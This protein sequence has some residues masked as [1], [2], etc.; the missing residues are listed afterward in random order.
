M[1]GSHQ[2]IVYGEIHRA[3]RPAPYSAAA[4]IAAPW[5][6]QDKKKRCFSRSR[7]NVAAAGQLKR[8]M[9]C[10]RDYCPPQLLPVLIAGPIS[11]KPSQSILFIFFLYYSSG[12]VS[13]PAG[14]SDWEATYIS[15]IS[16]TDPARRSVIR[17]FPFGE[18]GRSSAKKINSACLVNSFVAG[19]AGLLDQKKKE[20]T[21]CVGL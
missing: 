13:R 20:A 19:Q 6:E 10:V 21:Q 7:A 2:S 8:Y 4:A 18:T 5:L 1:T 12:A 3:G 16:L 11:V 14:P 15:F 9:Q 17:P